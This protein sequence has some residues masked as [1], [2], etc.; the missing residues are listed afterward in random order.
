MPLTESKG[1]LFS[2][3]AQTLVNTVNCVGIMGK[4]V[5]L[6]FR[7]RYPE[8]FE[9]YRRVCQDKSLRPGQILLHTDQQPWVLNLAVKDNWKQPSRIE[10]VQ[11][12]LEQ[13]VSGYR[14]LGIT[15][16]AFPWIGAMN[17]G[18]PWGHVHAL[19]RRYLAAVKDVEIEIVE[20]DPNSPDPLFVR[21]CEF[22]Q[23]CDP[24]AFAREVGIT[25]HAARIVYG[26]VIDGDAPS[27]FRLCEEP[28][29]GR[30]TVAHLYSRFRQG[31]AVVPVKEPSLFDRPSS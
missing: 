25:E 28:G 8:M 9:T 4:G 18:L 20:F 12:C 23:T 21:L 26:A 7:L 14:E 17:G 19:M 29:L 27:L 22:V 13:F 2:S 10:W 6:E 16:I 11:T 3:R 1:N 15:S 31:S 24:A 5:A 30:T